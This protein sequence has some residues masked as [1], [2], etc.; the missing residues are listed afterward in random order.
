MQPVTDSMP[1]T[2]QEL[3]A[4]I[5]TN[6]F[7]VLLA[8][9]TLVLTLA[10][11]Y[12]FSQSPFYIHKDSALF[13]HAGWYIGQGARL[14]V[15]IWDLKPPLIYAV[16]TVL[17]VLSGGD[18][19]LL[20]LIS[21]AVAVATNI[22]GVTLV[23]VLTHRLTDDGVASVVAGATIFGIT[24]VYMFPFAG[25]RPKYF[26]FLCTVAG[27]LL[28]VED[29]PFAS[30]VVA[31]MGAAFWQL[32]GL[33][34]VLVVGM[35]FQR[36]GRRGALRTLGGGV[37]MAVVTVLPFALTGDLVPL[38]VE[39]VLAPVYGVTRYTIPGRL[40]KFVIELGPG[41]L[42]VPLGVYGWGVA[43][44]DDY[45]EYWWIAVGGM[46]YLL[47]VFLEFQGAIE[48]IL[49]F[50]FLALGVGLLVSSASRP[51]RKWLLAGCIVLLVV[52][53]FHWNESDHTPVKDAVETE[54]EDWDV[55]NYQSLPPDP[56][57]WPSMQ[58]IYWE[59]RKPEYCHYRLGHKQKYFE[60]ETGGTLYKRTCGQWPYDDLPLDWV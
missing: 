29:R 31:A 55:P 3:H 27:L 8:G 47:Q 58:T 18:M 16:T 57:G 14:Y 23:G 30:G 24:T 19:H 34:A 60:Q 11:S 28:A 1:R 4:W 43:L 32:G 40:L 45:R 44:R 13:Q 38:F 22:A 7:R 35:G 6:W 20:H 50:V 59:K 52:T 9:A 36:G 15:D 56:E 17:A 5:D 26:A 25:I 39:A 33:V 12:Q 54:Y 53:S 51:S 21:I 46:L 2:W 37:T 41:V 42:A 49:L 10:T 48:M